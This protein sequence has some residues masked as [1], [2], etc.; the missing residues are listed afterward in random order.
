MPEFLYVVASFV[1]VLLT[2]MYFA[3]FAR[4]ISTWLPLDEDGPI[5]SFLYM[6]TEPV[7]MPIRAVLE[8]FEFFQNSPL[9]FSTFIAMLLVLVLQ[10]LLGIFV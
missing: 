9:D 3:L 8:N 2:V 5:V 1:D 7:V 4:A 10:G 6:I